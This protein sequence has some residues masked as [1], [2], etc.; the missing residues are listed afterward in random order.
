M[1]DLQYWVGF[2][3]IP[4]IGRARFSQLEGYFSNLE[5]AW[6]AGPSDLRAAGLDARTVNSIIA[7]RSKISLDA[8]MERLERHQVKALTRNDPAFPAKLKE[9][10]DVPPLLYIRGTLAPEDEWAVAVVGTRRATTY[11]R[12]TTER[13]V[14]DLVHNR[15]TIVSGLARG[16]DSIA[17]RTALEA[18]GRTIAIFA[19]G[20]DLVYPAENTQLAQSIM[21]KGALISE[22]P[23]GTRPKAE[24]FPRRN[25]ILA[26]LSLGVLVIE[27]DENSGALITA[28]HALE[29]NREVFAVPGSILSP[30]SRGTNRLIQD[31]AKLARNAQDILEELNLTMIPRQMEMRELIPANETEELLLGYLSHEPTHIDEVCRHS[32]LPIATVSSTLAM[33]ELK[34]MVRQLGGMNYTLART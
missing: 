14:A 12:Q 4:G 9:I 25:R 32:H 8:E 13:L 16:I 17:H 10:Y 33:M 6:Q 3:H 2:N 34:G 19:C 24:N 31:G 20:L 21:E 7:S 15:I 29:Q 1:T 27:A 28:N 11:G 23:L 26:G 18:G 22:Y 5:R 30:T